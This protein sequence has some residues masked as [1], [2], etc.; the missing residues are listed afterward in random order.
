MGATN[1]FNIGKYLWLPSKEIFGT[2]PGSDDTLLTAN[3]WLQ[4]IWAKMDDSEQMQVTGAFWVVISSSAQIPKE[5][6]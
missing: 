3:V 6:K 4:P 2:Y 5:K 1:A